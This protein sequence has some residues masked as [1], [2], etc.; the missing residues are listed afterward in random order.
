MKKK[1]PIVRKVVQSL[2][3][4]IAHRM[5]VTSCPHCDHNDM[6]YTSWHKGAVMLVTEIVQGKHGS[7]AVVS[8]CEK[9]FEKSWVHEMFSAFRCY[10]EYDAEWKAVAEKVE[11]ARHLAALHEFCDSLCVSC[12]HLRGLE[13]DTLCWKT[14]TMGR[15]DKTILPA[16]RK[17]YYDTGPARKE[18][19][20]YQKRV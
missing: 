19:D 17:F 1:K 8:E 7:M 13:G 5:G 4:G 20:K 11:N 12:V 2:P 10:D 3:A 16:G 6:D 9:C 14:C 15:D 18:C